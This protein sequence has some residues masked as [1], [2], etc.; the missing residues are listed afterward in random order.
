MVIPIL[1]IGLIFFLLYLIFIHLTIKVIFD[2]RQEGLALTMQAFI[3][4]I[5]AFKHL[6]FH[7]QNLDFDLLAALDWIAVY[8]R[9][10]K[11]RAKYDDVKAYLIRLSLHDGLTFF[12]RR[13]HYAV[14]EE[15]DWVSGIG[16]QDAMY[17]GIA[18]G[19]L[20]MIIGMF[21]SAV[22][23]LCRLEKLSLQVDPV[24]DVEIFRTAIHCI[25]KIRIA[26]I[27]FIA[28]DLLFMIV[29][30]YINGYRPGKAAEPS[31]RRTH[32][33]GYAKY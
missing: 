25:I 5:P 18:T 2:Q 26:H 30:G 9:C 14:M 31:Y 10:I 11:N 7:Y 12:K 29:R 17:T 32:A 6:V 19:A 27:I 16:C 4:I 3:H 28:V 15:L 8:A 23:L 13:S 20:W 24:Y 33:N 21:I 22:S 1:V